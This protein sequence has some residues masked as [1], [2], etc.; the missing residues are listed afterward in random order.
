MT[1]VDFFDN[2]D[3]IIAVAIILFIIIVFLGMLLF[4][5]KTNE[6]AS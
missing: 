4:H 5:K 2:T 3:I 1:S 6:W